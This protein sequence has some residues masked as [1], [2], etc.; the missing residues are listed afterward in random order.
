MISY[1]PFMWISK[2]LCWIDKIKIHIFCCQMNKYNKNPNS[3]FQRFCYQYYY[4]HF[5][6]MSFFEIFN[7]IK[8]KHFSQIKMIINILRKGM[9]LYLC[10]KQHSGLIKG[11]RACIRPIYDCFHKLFSNILSFRNNMVWFNF[12]HTIFKM[13]FLL[14]VNILDNNCSL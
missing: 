6:E 13:I 2:W 10:T 14:N 12:S 7:S 9:K 1:S 8:H 3:T 4:R 5:N 11:P